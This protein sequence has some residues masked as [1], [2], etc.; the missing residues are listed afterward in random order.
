MPRLVRRKPLWERI[1]S[2]LNPRDFSLWLSEEIETRDL[3]AKEVGTYTGLALNFIF[4][5]ARGSSAAAS[6]SHDDVFADDRGSG[7]LSFFVSTTL[8][9]PSYWTPN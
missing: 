8:M 1:T 7:W 5:L 4:L 9:L 2:S 6:A 3:D